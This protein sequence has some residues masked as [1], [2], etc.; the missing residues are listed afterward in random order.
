MSAKNKKQGIKSPADLANMAT[1]PEA[2]KT[3][4]PVATAANAM[5]DGDENEQEQVQLEHAGL[6]T[7]NEQPEVKA[8]VVAPVDVKVQQLNAMLQRYKTA[9]TLQF[10][11]AQQQQQAADILFQIVHFVMGNSTNPVLNAIF[12]FFTTEHT[13]LMAEDVVFQAAP[14][15]QDAQRHLETFYAVF[16][17]LVYA[18]KFGKKFTL[19][20]DAIRHVLKND[21]IVNFVH[22]KLNL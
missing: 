5:G 7:I 2:L 1:K 9:A 21:N 13:G 16:K 22:G 15:F 12:T 17:E 10:P 6:G 8:K 11:T 20:L 14:K 4:V 3:E 19:N 18:K